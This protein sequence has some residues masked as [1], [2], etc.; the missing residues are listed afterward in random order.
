MD[1]TSALDDG[2]KVAEERAAERDTESAS[3]K[4]MRTT[5]GEDGGKRVSEGNLESGK[6]S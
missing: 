2:S 3:V 1:R 5:A 6:F 4:G